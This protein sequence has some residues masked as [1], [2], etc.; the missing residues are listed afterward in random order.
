MQI[1]AISI[2]FAMPL[3]LIDT[4]PSAGPSENSRQLSHLISWDDKDDNDN[5]DNRIIKG[6]SENGDQLSHLIT[7]KRHNNKKI[8][9]N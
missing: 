7:L 5:N 3:C 9:K 1:L 6:P 8:R 4:S 2:I